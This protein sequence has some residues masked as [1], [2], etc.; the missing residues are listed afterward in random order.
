MAA[1][2][3]DTE[4]IARSI[5]HLSED[6][7]EAAACAAR[8]VKEAESATPGADSETGD[9]Q[10][11]EQAIISY[12]AGLS[13]EERDEAFERI[14][15]GVNLT[16]PV[17]EVDPPPP[18]TTM[19]A[20]RAEPP[21]PVDG[22]WGRWL[23]RGEMTSIAARGGVG[24]TTFTR[25]L[26]LRSAMGGSFMGAPFE[27]PLTWLY[28]TREGAG[29][30]FRLKLE[31]LGDALGVEA[32]AEDRLHFVDKANDC[33]LLLS[34]PTDLDQIRRDIDHVKSAPGG[35]DVVVFDPF[36]RF[37]SGSENDDKDM[38]A[39]VDAILGLQSEFDVAS[40]VPHHSSQSGVG[41]DAWRGHTTFEG[42]MA[43]G[44]LLTDKVAGEPNPTTRRLEIA[45]ARYAFTLEDR[46][47]RHFDCDVETEVYGEREATGTEARIREALKRPGADWMT[48]VALAAE[49][50]VSRSTVQDHVKRLEGAEKVETDRNGENGAVRARWVSTGLGMS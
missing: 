50:E 43:T 18:V 38:A 31:R 48:Y 22:L 33:N 23:H 25:N 19:R 40:W 6:A 9:G 21:V 36:T 10:P 44:F 45:K 34:R 4:T 3:V 24:K 47:S 2:G 26:M 16:A 27:R 14:N 32:D 17:D 35:L 5:A 8:A 39:A 28:F 13:T 7:D 42:G 12:F 1:R 20:M 37:K 41:L 30:Y 49:V 15:T 29:S 11:S 46:Q